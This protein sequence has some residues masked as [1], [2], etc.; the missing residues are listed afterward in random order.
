MNDYAEK[1]RGEYNRQY[2][3]LEYEEDSMGITAK[4]SGG[5][6]FKII[7][8]GMKQAVCYMVFDLGTQ[9]S[10]YYKKSDRKVL[11]GWE[12]PDERIDMDGV[13][14]PMVIS[15]RYTLSLHEKA[16]LRKDLE[17]WRSKRFTAEELEGFDIAKLLGV[18]CNLQV[19]H[20]E[21]GDKTYA[22]VQTVTPLMK[23][24]DKLE[25]EGEFLY[26]SFEDNTPFPEGS[27]EWI[28]KVAMKSQEWK[29]INIGQ[30]DAEDAAQ[31]EPPPEGEDDV[32]F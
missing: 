6:D 24:Q 25:C 18:N 30:P 15:K 23:G 5:G 17:A 11:I 1:S 20:N 27:P 7:P 28:E 14:M 21:S 16:T 4:S 13:S 29:D 10:E 32:P 8:E 2:D 26:F 9:Y 19:L 12:I 31:E 3:N 22:N